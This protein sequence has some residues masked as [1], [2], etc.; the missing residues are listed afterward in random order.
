MYPRIPI[1]APARF[2][3]THIS[4]VQR[5]ACADPDI[6]ERA[7][8]TVARAYW[9]PIYAY[10][11]LTHGA[12]PEDAED[13][14]QGFFAEVLRRDLFAR[15]DPARARFRTYVRTC[16]DAFVANERKGERRLKRGGAALMVSLDLAGLEER[17]SAGPGVDEIFDREWVR[18]VF[19][20]AVDRLRARCRE[21]GRHAHLALFERY[22][23]ADIAGREAPTYAVLAAD[24]GITTTQATNWL[25][26]VR[27]DFRAIVLETLRELCG[28]DDE[29]RA[30]A[31]ALLGVE[32]A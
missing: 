21:T 22:D 12:S 20:M 19:A 31:R 5:M 17:L 6:R 7:L 29:L 24:L 3:A 15:F 4:L 8:D 25:A 1:A 14:T 32:V 30:E 11:R 27:R 9:A 18:A 16:V 23:L 10:I 28:S 13:L 2:P 26:A